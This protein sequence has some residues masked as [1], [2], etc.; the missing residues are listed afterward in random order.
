MRG[1]KL[2]MK[3]LEMPTYNKPEVRIGAEALVLE[4]TIVAPVLEPRRL[5]R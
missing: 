2:S 5:R 1:E 4:P 3:D